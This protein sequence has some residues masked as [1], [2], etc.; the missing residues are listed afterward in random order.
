MTSP[1]EAAEPFCPRSA[2]SL[3]EGLTAYTSGCAYANHLDDVDGTARVGA[4]P[5]STVLDRDPFAGPSERIA[6]TRVTRTYVEGELVF[7]APTEA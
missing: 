6:D 5:T 3:A 1:G 2:I 4:T 7:T